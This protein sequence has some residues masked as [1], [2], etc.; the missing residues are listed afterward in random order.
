MPSV[1][2]LRMAR[3]WQTSLELLLAN[4]LDKCLEKGGVG[5]ERR[6]PLRDSSGDLRTP[7]R[8][9]LGHLRTPL[10]DSS[11]RLRTPLRDCSNSPDSSV[12]VAKLFLLFCSL[13]YLWEN[14][15]LYM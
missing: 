2:H 13:E 11:G 15:E 8:D 1:N 12:S 7:L 10:R 3:K 6:T 4:A 14:T 5:Q 9:R